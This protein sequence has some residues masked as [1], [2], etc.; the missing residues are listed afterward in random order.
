MV[1]E[2]PV[3]EKF[4]HWNSTGSIR[5]LMGQSKELGS[6]QLSNRAVNA[7]QGGDKNWTAASN[8]WSR[9]CVTQVSA[10]ALAQPWNLRITGGARFIRLPTWLEA[11]MPCTPSSPRGHQ[12][13][14]VSRPETL[15]RVP[16]RGGVPHSD[17]NLPKEACLSTFQVTVWYVV[18]LSLNSCL[19]CCTTLCVTQVWA[20]VAHLLSLRQSGELV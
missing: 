11:E 18:L 20:Y 13:L 7:W 8:S 5:S 15:L 12:A 4:S 1:V 17:T 3:C 2:F 10:E 16:A 9:L 14:T 6:L 19:R